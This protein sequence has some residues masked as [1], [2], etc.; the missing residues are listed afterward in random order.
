MAEER[1]I[2]GIERAAPQAVAE[3]ITCRELLNLR[4]V[5]GAIRPVGR[6]PVEITN[7]TGKALHM[8]VM[9]TTHNLI[10]ISG[11]TLYFKNLEDDTTTQI[12]NIE[13]EL[14]DINHLNKV[15]VVSTTVRK[16]EYIYSNDEKNYIGIPSAETYIDILNLNQTPYV[17]DTTTDWDIANEA[18]IAYVISDFEYNRENL[19]N[20]YISLLPKIA[21]KAQQKAEEGSVEGLVFIRIAI[22]LIDGTLIY[23]STI[24]WKRLG[25]NPWQIPGY[26][27]NEYMPANGFK[28]IDGF[29]GLWY[30]VC[31]YNTAVLKINLRHFA[32]LLSHSDSIAGIDVF[33]TPPAS[34]YTPIMEW[35]INLPQSGWGLTYQPQNSSADATL[36]TVLEKEQSFFLAAEFSL[37]DIRK[38]V[39]D[40]N[41]VPVAITPN[42]STL[43]TNESMSL[44]LI[45]DKLHS[46]THAC[47]MLYN[48]R[49]ITGNISTKL[50]AGYKQYSTTNTDSHQV[51]FDFEINTEYGTR[52]VYR[53]HQAHISPFGVVTLPP[54]VI[55]PDIRAKKLRVM[56]IYNNSTTMA[57]ELVSINMT[58]HK[59]LNFAYAK[60]PYTKQYWYDDRIPYT[61]PAGN[62][63]F[64]DPNRVQ[65]SITGNALIM[66]PENSYEVGHSVVLGFGVSGEPVSTGQFGQYP[67]YTFT[68]EGIYVMDVGVEPFISSIRQINGE[69]C[70]SPKTIRNIGMG[71]L[72]TTAKGLMIINALQV[73]HLSADFT[74]DYRNSF[75]IDLNPLWQQAINFD[76]TGKP[77]RFLSTVPFRDY[78]IDAKIGFDYP[79]REIWVNNGLY[80][81]SYVFS[82]ES[83]AWSKRDET[84]SAIVFDYPNCYAQKGTLCLNL[85]KRESLDNMNIFLMSN[86]VKLSPDTFKQFR[87]MIA[88]G[89]FP[90]QH[91]GFYLFS[92]NDGFSWNFAGGKEIDSKARD[93]VFLGKHRAA[94]YSVIMIVGIVGYDWNMT[95]VSI[96]A[97]LT[98]TKKLR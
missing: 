71:V 89:E 34:Y 3:E 96:D 70:N 2:K 31:P 88:R 56:V 41:S 69:V 75:A 66:P 33:I 8:H 5:R 45:D 42:Y 49:L 65:A 39:D 53:T 12:G 17:F 18:R 73:Q 36:D 48:Q 22:R 11:Q 29:D 47:S 87:R 54:F 30:T 7:I 86:S 13:G 14:L 40:E 38:Y 60:L 67:I 79:N 97:V 64:S 63:M 27:P 58:P 80:T 82:L 57:V 83:Q 16:Y 76:E 43:V 78:I 24:I 28:Y 95:G 6:K 72:F 91:A 55:Y 59:I 25:G 93:I 26:V 1:N 98:E 62:D 68:A 46:I 4:H 23:P 85:S 21:A 51:V 9:D 90:V 84:F 32:E 37:D 52:R 50:F 61:L 77:S 20:S 81:Y 44:R 94:K 15:L 92:S 10:S 74:E 19:Q 35:K